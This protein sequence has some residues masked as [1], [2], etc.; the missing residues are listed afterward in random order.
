MA[1]PQTANG[2]VRIANELFDEIANRDFNKQELNVLLCVIRNTYGWNRKSHRLSCS[3]ISDY[4]GLDRSNVSRARSTLIGKKVLFTEGYKI[5]IQK[6]FDLWRVLSKQQHRCCR[7]NN[8]SVV[9]T[10]TNKDSKDKIN[11]GA[12]TS[13]EEENLTLI[14]GNTRINHL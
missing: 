11:K 2:Y 3:F 14:M 4:T 5:G 9:K 10:T 13:F 1:S 12:T 8:K 7:N 6:N